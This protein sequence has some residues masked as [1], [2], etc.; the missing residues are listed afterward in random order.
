MDLDDKLT[1]SF[2]L[3]NLAEQVLRTKR[4]FSL[5]FQMHHYHHEWTNRLILMACQSVQGYFMPRSLEIMLIVCLYSF[6]VV[7][8]SGFFVNSYISII[9]I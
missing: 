8:S 2:K 6:V 4:L 9:P 1:K 7:T 5:W 3:N